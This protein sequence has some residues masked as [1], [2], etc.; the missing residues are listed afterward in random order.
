[1]Q[2]IIRSLCILALFLPVGAARAGSSA[3]GYVS[4]QKLLDLSGLAWLG[5]DRFL[6]VHDAKNPDEPDR[7]RV[8]FLK[9][10]QSLEGVQWKPLEVAFPGGASSDLESAA[11]VPGTSQ[12]LLVESGDDAGRYQR[13]FLADTSETGVSIAGVVEWGAFNQVYNVEATAVVQGAGGYRFLWAERSSGKQ[14]TSIK[15]ADMT[16]SPF[17]IGSTIGEAAFALPAD[18]VGADGKPLYS[19]P[20]VGMDVGSAGQ[21]YVVAA[22]DPEGTVPDPDNGPFRSAVLKIGTMTADGLVLDPAPTMLLRVEGFKAESVVIAGDP[23]QIYIGTDDENY[24]GVL[25][26]LLP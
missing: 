22:Y 1:M 23:P 9:S 26:R 18:L 8:S 7:V 15:W 3:D 24:G 11:A 20:V 4:V 10:P 16:L 19:R 5:G 2:C 13:I 12:V 17:S 25:R 21:V 6:A 14:A